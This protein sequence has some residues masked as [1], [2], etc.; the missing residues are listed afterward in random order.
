MKRAQVTHGADHRAGNRA[1][2]PFLKWAGGKRQLLP[3]LREFYPPAFGAYHEPFLGSAAVFFDLAESGALQRGRVRLTDV[4]ADLIGCCL[5]LRDEPHA[6]VRHL[7]KLEAGYA[8]AP[9]E[10][11][12]RNWDEDFNPARAGITNA[13]HPR[14]EAYSPELA[15]M[16]IYLNRTGYNGL[17][18][19]NSSGLFNVPRGRNKNPRICDEENLVRVSSTLSELSVKIELLPFETVVKSARKGDFVYFDP[20]YAPL[21]AT[22]HFT[23]YTSDGFDTA[24]Q[25]ELQRVVFE[26][27]RK[28]CHVVLSNSTAPEIKEL[29]TDNAVAERLHIK[30]HTVPARRAINSNAS[31]RGHVDEYIITNVPRRSV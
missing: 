7:R 30:A 11:Y 3:R 2:R 27:V 18:R 23:S 22:A 4:N 1:L 16:L 6:V 25:R 15:G 17:F 14:P 29:Y 8:A 21:S 12:Y 19:L 10:H 24:D 5:R 26:L 9:E 20:P 31:R 28:G 13:R